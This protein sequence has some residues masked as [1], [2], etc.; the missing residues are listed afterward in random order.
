[1]AMVISSRHRL[2][3]SLVLAATGLSVGGCQNAVS[4]GAFNRCG[5]DIEIQADSVSESSSRWTILGAGDRDTMVDLPENAETL[6]VRVRAPGTEEI[7]NVDLP[8]TSL[9][10]PPTDVDYEAR[11][12]LAGDRCP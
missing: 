11:L 9:G 10:R 2:I 5:A 4:V 1:M 6:Y 12:V 8:M 7:R 3:G